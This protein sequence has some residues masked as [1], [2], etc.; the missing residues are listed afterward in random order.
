[1]AKR[2][3]QR[4]IQG[5]R[6]PQAQAEQAVPTAPINQKPWQIAIVCA[7]L[8]LATVFIY[9]G[10]RTSEFLTYDDLGYVQDNQR[11]HQGLTE[12]SIEWAFTSFDV[13]N[14]HPLTWISHMVDWQLYGANPSGHHMT[15]VYLHSASAILLFLLLLYMTGY[16]WRAAIVAFLF[17]LHPAHAESVAWVSERK[18]VLCTFF[19]FATILVYAWYAR[20]LIMEAVRMGISG[21]RLCS[22]VKAHGGHV[23]HSPCC[24]STTGR[25]VESRSH[26]KR[27][28]IG[29]P[30][31]SSYLLKKFLSSFWL[32][33]P[34]SSLLLHNEP[35]VQWQHLK[36]FPYGK[37]D[38]ERGHQL[39]PLCAH[40][41]LARPAD[42]LL[43]P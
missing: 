15:N 17:A 5:K 24:C 35:V 14:W 8:V 31:S 26:R 32:Q 9:R 43:L 12:K 20:K 39:L 6:P 33:S 21:L 22:H 4:K 7:V 42:S 2:S 16:F 41:V 1:M 13:S 29:P 3:R 11:V 19:W 28:S 27:P 36:P 25:C 23:F 18:D 38:I 37:R 40:Y 30:H 34:V 10:V